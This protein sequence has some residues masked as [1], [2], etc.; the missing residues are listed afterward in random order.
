MISNKIL[1]EPLGRTVSTSGG[2]E[3][4]QM[5]SE[6]RVVCQRGH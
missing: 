2:L 3:L 6:H 5:V 4:L 1:R